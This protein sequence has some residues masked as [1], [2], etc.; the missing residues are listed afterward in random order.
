MAGTYEISNEDCLTFLAKLPDK[1]VNLVLC[2]PPYGITAAKDWDNGLRWNELW[3]E[4][5]RILAPKGA[6]A[7]FSSSK[8]TFELVNTNLK[9]FRY[10]YVWVK[11]LTSGHLN[12]GRMPMRMYEEINIFYPKQCAF[13]PQRTS[14]HKK[15]GIRRW[16]ECYGQ[17]TYQGYVKTDWLDTDGTRAPKDVLKFN[18]IQGFK[19]LHPSEKPTELLEHLIKTYTQEGETVLDFCMGSGSTGEACY[20]TNRHFVG[21]EL[22]EDFYTMAKTRLELLPYPERYQAYIKTHPLKALKRKA[23]IEPGGGAI[24]VP[25]CTDA[26]LTG[27]NDV[28]EYSD[29]YRKRTAIRDNPGSRALAQEEASHRFSL[30]GKM[31]FH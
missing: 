30:Y 5:H 2:D 7:L 20:N 11:N 17:S 19:K 21:C 28:I 25:S 12:A 22:S 9:E 13:Y 6:V 27:A 31:T 23:A 16:G 1:S 8:F 14:G 29:K 4:I 26:V 3:P 18:A 15:N 24:M 10:K